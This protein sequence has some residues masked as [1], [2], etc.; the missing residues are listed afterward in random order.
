M[1][2]KRYENEDLQKWYEKIVRVKMK[3]DKEY[4][5]LTE[6][7]ADEKYYSSKVNE[8]IKAINNCSSHF[9]C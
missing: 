5:E 3:S 8:V 6:A 1:I 4:L 7:D 9:S 2:K